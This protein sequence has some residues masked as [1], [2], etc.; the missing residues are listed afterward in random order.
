[1]SYSS[2]NDL[3]DATLVRL[4]VIWDPGEVL[5]FLEAW[6]EDIQIKVTGLWRLEVPREQ[7]WAHSVSINSVKGFALPD[8]KHHRLEIEMQSGDTII[9][10][11]ENFQLTEIEGS[12]RARKSLS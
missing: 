10:E 7:P 6:P 2:W 12:R 5:L 9:L 8:G 11:A 3:H 4:D 1:M